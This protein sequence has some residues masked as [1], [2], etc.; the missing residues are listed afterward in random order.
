MLDSLQEPTESDMPTN[1][2]EIVWKKKLETTVEQLVEQN[3]ML[4]E[5]N[6]N[7]SSQIQILLQCE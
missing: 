2:M 5:Q 4:V 6:K 3:N 1:L 7:L